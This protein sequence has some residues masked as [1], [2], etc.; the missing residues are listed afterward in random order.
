MDVTGGIVELISKM[1]RKPEVLV[2]SSGVDYYGDTG[3]KD[4]HED[5]PPANSYL[6]KLTHDWE[7]AALKAEKYGTRVVVLRTGFVMASDSEAVK[8]LLMPFK[9][10]VGGPL[11]SGKQYISWIHI[12]DLVGI[13]MYAIDNKN[14]SGIYNAA[15]PNPETNINFGRQAAKILHRPA[16]A[17][18]PAFMIKLIVGEMAAVVLEGR[19][20]MPD[21]IIEAGYRF[22]FEHSA[23]AWKEVL[24]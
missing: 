4:M 23:D 3:S 16:I 17:P 13:Y 20:A 8:K 7:E 5:A 6:G 2:S 18:A 19:R 15:A 22:K 12:D 21:K 10:F 11:G 14:V 9:F 1:G 24:K